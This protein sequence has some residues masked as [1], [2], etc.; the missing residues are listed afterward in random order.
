MYQTRRVNKPMLVL[1]MLGF[2]LLMWLSSL[3]GSWAMPR[4]A[5]DLPTG[6]LSGYVIV[7]GAQTV[8]STIPVPCHPYTIYIELIEQELESASQDLPLSE[9]IPLAAD[10]YGRFEYCGIPPGTYSVI[11]RGFNTLGNL[12]MD[13]YVPPDGI[14]VVDFGTLTPGDANGNNT[15]DIL[16]Y[17]ILAMIYGDCSGPPDWDRRPD[18]DCSGCVGILDYSLLAA[19]YGWTGDA[20][21]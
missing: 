19:H 15:V 7:G 20:I 9:T 4:S 17:S 18:F 1:F 16:D 5:A 21:P 8:G 2:C 11:V 12:R 6:C 14:A 3:G 10:E 13:I